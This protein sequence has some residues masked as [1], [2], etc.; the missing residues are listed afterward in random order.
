[1]AKYFHTWREF[2]VPLV[3]EGRGIMIEWINKWE[4]K[5]DKDTKVINS[6]KNETDFLITFRRSCA[7]WNVT[8]EHS[9]RHR[10]ILGSTARLIL[11]RSI[12][13][14]PH[15]KGNFSCLIWV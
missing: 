13:I 15:T 1:M 6:R 14:K 4:E 8:E 7:D 9:N 2:E 5:G 3:E 11:C 10:E 12:R